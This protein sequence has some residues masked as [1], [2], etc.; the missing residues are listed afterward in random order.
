M[1]NAK[2]DPAESRRRGSIA[3]VCAGDPRNKRG[4]LTAGCQLTL[5]R[6][7]RPS[8][9][10]ARRY[11]PRKKNISN[12]TYPQISLGRKQKSKSSIL[13]TVLALCTRSHSNTQYKSLGA[14]GCCGCEGT[15]P[16]GGDPG[17]PA[18]PGLN[19][20][21]ASKWTHNMPDTP[22]PEIRD[23]PV[24]DADR[25]AVGFSTLYFRNSEI[26]RYNVIIG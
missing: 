24:I 17:D 16:P 21:P 23:R 26:E 25:P 5:V 9:I 10:G 19:P 2:R 6:R 3:C 20:R 7:T 11:E 12:G 14:T 1:A 8:Q 4:R 18:P 15:T 22:P 13:T